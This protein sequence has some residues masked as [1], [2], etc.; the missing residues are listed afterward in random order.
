[1]DDNNETLT[2]ENINPHVIDV[3]YAIRGPIV[4]HAEEIESKI[5]SVYSYYFDELLLFIFF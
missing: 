3:E 5:E 1:M 4:I 2:I